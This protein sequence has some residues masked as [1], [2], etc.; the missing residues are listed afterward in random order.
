MHGPIVGVLLAAGSASR[1][2]GEKLLAP[3]P[4]GT[5]IGVAALEH[6]AAAVDSVV[7][8]VRPHDAP[9]A[10]ALAARGARITRSRS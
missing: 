1:F 9:L 6:L 4:D 5:P 3:L 7:A 10:A 8:V 2:G